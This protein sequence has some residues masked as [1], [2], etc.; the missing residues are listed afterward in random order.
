MARRP[1][2]RTERDTTATGAPAPDDMGAGLFGEIAQIRHHSV[3]ASYRQHGHA[4]ILPNGSTM[5]QRLLQLQLPI[6]LRSA[7][8]SDYES[9]W[10]LDYRVG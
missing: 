9:I 8:Y 4:A 1:R 5:I 7:Q 3:L 2:R 10:L 6:H